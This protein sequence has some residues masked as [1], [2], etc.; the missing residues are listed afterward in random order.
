MKILEKYKTM[1]KDEYS[2]KLR[3]IENDVVR[4]YI[5]KIA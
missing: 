2:E 4:E 5:L 1:G 3:E